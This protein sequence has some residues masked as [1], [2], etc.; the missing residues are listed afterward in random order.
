MG[1]QSAGRARYDRIATEEIGP[2]GFWES[3]VVCRSETPLDDLRAVTERHDGIEDHS[4]RPGGWQVG[5]Y[6]GAELADDGPA[7]LAEL[8][9]ETGSPALAGFVLDSDTIHV[10]GFSAS[11][12]YWRACLSRDAA[13]AYCEDDD[14]D[15]A[16]E[17]PTAEEAARS[18]AAWSVEAGGTP[19]FPGLVEVFAIAESDFAEALYFELLDRLGI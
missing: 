9:A 11:G 18:A 4:H 5:Q 16:A 19:D 3:F 7:M 1:P 15:F 2:V 10:E 14:E 12:G 13:E 17:F 8:A 6:P